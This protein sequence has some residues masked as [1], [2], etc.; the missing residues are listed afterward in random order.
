MKKSLTD[1]TTALSGQDF[2]ILEELIDSKY[3]KLRKF[4]KLLK[5][6]TDDI[7][8]M[9]Y[10]VNDDKETFRAKVTF[11]KKVSLD[12]KKDLVEK[13]KEVGYGVD[14][15]FEDKVMDITIKYKEK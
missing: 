10:I 11:K 1:Y 15:K 3:L 14:Y 9:K 13:W 8:E 2:A 5:P 7:N 4:F 12:N 6:H